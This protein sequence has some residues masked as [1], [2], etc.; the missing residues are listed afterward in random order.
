M[1]PTTKQTF[2]T[3]KT[4]S[5]DD[6]NHTT[7]ATRSNTFKIT[8]FKYLQNAF[9]AKLNF[10]RPA[11]RNSSAQSNSAQ[12]RHQ[13]FLILCTADTY[14]YLSVKDKW[15][16]GVMWWSAKTFLRSV[17]RKVIIICKPFTGAVGDTVWHYKGLLAIW[18]KVV[19]FHLSIKNSD[20]TCSLSVGQ[21]SSCHLDKESLLNPARLARESFRGYSDTAERCKD[22]LTICRW[23]CL[24]FRNSSHK[25]DPVCL[26]H[27]DDL[28][29][30]CAD[31]RKVSV[32][33]SW[34]DT[35]IG[36]ETHRL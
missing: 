27:F 33:I 4:R 22:L 29:N 2:S 32:N 1:F 25:K 24:C 17:V 5:N 20:V 15:R 31:T 19:Y 8:W 28:E 18:R 10:F 12:D 16:C 36:T 13:E 14:L 26:H 7:Q 9:A 6:Q 11:R 23:I 3:V 34:T 30:G 35:N 21:K